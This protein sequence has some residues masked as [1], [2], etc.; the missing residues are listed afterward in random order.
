MCPQTIS[1]R[2]D[3]K[4]EWSYFIE[5]KIQTS[6]QPMAQSGRRWIYE[7]VS[8]TEMRQFPK[9]LV[10]SKNRPCTHKFIVVHSNYNSNCELQFVAISFSLSLPITLTQCFCFFEFFPCRM[11]AG[12]YFH[13]RIPCPLFRLY[14][15]SWFTYICIHDSFQTKHKKQQQ[16]YATPVVAYIS[17]AQS[18]RIC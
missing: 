17:C 3:T 14:R 12:L 7:C 6:T 8:C 15:S 4:M 10:S 1:V 5:E 18:L 9:C 13:V 2:Q 16:K 11:R